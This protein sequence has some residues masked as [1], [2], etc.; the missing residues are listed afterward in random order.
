MSKMI[1]IRVNEQAD[2][3]FYVFED[4]RVYPFI[5]S[6]GGV[7]PWQ[8]EELKES[9]QWIDEGSPLGPFETIDCPNYSEEA[10]ARLRNTFEEAETEWRAG[11]EEEK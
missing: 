5:Q 3:R 4:G 11:E 10:N 7:G 1:E 2:M 6:C 8:E 9:S